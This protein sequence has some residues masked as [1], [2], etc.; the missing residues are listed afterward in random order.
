MGFEMTT[1]PVAAAQPTSPDTAPWL[2]VTRLEA[3]T[4]LDRQFGV[5]PRLTVPA[6]LRPHLF[7]DP[8]ADT[9]APR[10]R[11]FALLDAAA[12]PQ[13]PERLA[14]SG[15]THKCLF[16][17]ET[18]QKLAEAAPWLVELKDDH[19]FTRSLMTTEKAAGLWEREL[20]IYLRSSMPFERLWSHCRKF[21]RL[22]DQ[23]GKWLYFR[24]WAP[25]VS[26]RAMALGNRTELVQLFS[27]LFPAAPDDLTV[28][29]LSRDLS[30]VMARI[31]GTAP[32][33]RRPMLTD[34]AQETLRQIRRIQQFEEI[35]EI[36]LRHVDAHTDR[37]HDEIRDHLRGKRDKFFRMG[38]WRRDHLA[39][40]A[41]WEV[42]LGPD[43]VETY[44][45]GAIKDY[46]R[47]SEVAHEVID[48]IEAHLAAE[49]EARQQGRPRDPADWT[50]A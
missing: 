20:G 46:L 9:D 43:F 36:T 7:P 37:D 33:P 10:Q 2:E 17:G 4:P 23:H 49:E 8:P 22:E 44:A 19:P 11:S 31:P 1:G 5:H 35:I 12:L 3:V 13:L 40:L 42:L 24:Y 48:K 38:F 47:G 39:K 26:T 30:A 6:T 16:S 50:G 28:I 34:A 21:T 18:G 29:L 15:L 27:P 41:C 14:T 45:G 25:P 32:P